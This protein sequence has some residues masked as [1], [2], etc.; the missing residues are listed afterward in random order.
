M[1]DIN[2]LIDKSFYRIKSQ[3]IYKPFYHA[4]INFHTNN[5]NNRFCERLS[6]SAKASER[7]YS[8][9]TYSTGISF[10]KNNPLDLTIGHTPEEIEECPFYRVY[11]NEIW[12]AKS[13][14]PITI[15]YKEVVN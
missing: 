15:K 7:Y 6:N 14:E 10:K 5:I 2:K 11:N 12:Q 3:T 13:S 9:T 8:D 1:D 4:L